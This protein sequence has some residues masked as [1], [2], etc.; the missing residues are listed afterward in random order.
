MSP[1]H[2]RLVQESWRQLQPS[3]PQAAELFYSRLF[4]LDPSVRK[5]F[6]TDLKEQGT[7]LMSMISVAVGALSR[8][9]SILPAVQDLGRRQARYG[10]EQRHYSVVGA[11]LVWTLQQQLGKAF[12]AEVEQAWRTVYGVLSTTMQQ[13]TASQEIS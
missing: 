2:I 8:L 1:E 10:V 4:A 11:A 13:A 6:R 9:E 7:K 5:L 3:A 12:T